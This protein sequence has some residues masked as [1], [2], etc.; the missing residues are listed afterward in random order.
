MGAN[1]GTRPAHRPSRREDLIHVAAELF[2]LQ[3]W[4]AVTVNAIVRSA[5]M[6]S[7]AFYYHFASRE[8]VLEV[9]VRR[10]AGHWISI[11]EE[12]EAC[13]QQDGHDVD[14]ELVDQLGA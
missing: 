8:E 10:F 2:A 6:T 4:Q 1:T 12:A 5:G 13:T 7:A 11:V 14:A 3:P 9:V